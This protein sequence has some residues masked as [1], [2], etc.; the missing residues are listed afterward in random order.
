[1][2]RVILTIVPLLAASAA[3]AGCGSSSKTSGSSTQSGGSASP[4]SAT[5]SGGYGGAGYGAG[6]SSASSSSS[7]GGSGS[8]GSSSA[9]ALNTKHN[10]LGM[11]LAA[12]PRQLT[13]YL[14]EGD[15][16]ATSNCSGA[17]ASL[18]PPVTTSGSPGVHG[19]AVAANLG[20]ITRSDGT[21][22]VTYKGH[23]LYYFTR[24]KDS[25]D[26]YGQGIKAF[27]AS[28]YVLAPSGRKIDNS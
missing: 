15:K 23:P 6:A 17:C 7:S 1:V 26:A 13:V 24:D 3:I 27:G 10:K 9:A 5:T 4:A 25:G 12:G 11:I 14:F 21:K 18:W 2:K 20:T 28:W 19:Q 8:S 16:G 22:Q